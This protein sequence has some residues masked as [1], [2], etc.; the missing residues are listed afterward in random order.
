VNQGGGAK[1]RQILK[2]LSGVGKRQEGAA[3][4]RIKKT[5]TFR[6]SQT[7]NCPKA[8]KAGGFTE[9]GMGPHGEEKVA[10]KRKKKNQ[11]L[12]LKGL[13]EKAKECE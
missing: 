4:K 13:T 3:F 7:T 5:Q 8:E 12:A 6:V 9:K 2:G 1:T 10:K 11:S